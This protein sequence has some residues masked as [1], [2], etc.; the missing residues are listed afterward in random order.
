MKNLANHLCGCVLVMLAALAVITTNVCGQTVLYVRSDVRGGGD[1]LSWKTAYNDLQVAL[2][3]AEGD[4]S[5]DQIWVAAG[6]YTPA[7]PDGDREL[8][9]NLI[10]GVAIYGHFAGFETSIHE[11]DFSNPANET[12]LS[13]DLNGDDGPDFQN[14]GENSYHVVSAVD[15]DSTALLDGFTIRGGNAD[16]TAGGGNRTGGGILLDSSSALIAN[17]QIVKNRALDGGSAIRTR[18]TSS[19]VCH[20]CYLA[21]NLGPTTVWI[22]GEFIFWR[23]RIVENLGSG[24]NSANNTVRLYNCEVTNNQG[25]GVNLQNSQ[26]SVIVQSVIANSQSTGVNLQGSQGPVIVQSVIANNA[27]NIN[28]SGTAH[29]FIYNTIIY[30]GGGIS[31]GMHT[32]E[33]SCIRAGGR[34][35][36]TSIRTRS[37]S[38]RRRAIFASSPARRALMPVTTMRCRRTSSISTATGTRMNRFRSILTAGCASSTIR[39]RPTPATADRPLSIWVPMSS[40]A[41]PIPATTPSGQTTSAASMKH[42]RTGR[43]LRRAQTPTYCSRCTNRTHSG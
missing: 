9:F 1:G 21:A 27:G 30:G 41:S 23:S 24:I 8:S 40:S 4:G 43:L 20:D 14:Y 10:S 31:H 19:P 22:S 35:S 7:P 38:I 29:S 25:T 39:R 37:S 13:G 32:V 2:A 36:G 5:V 33:Y 16:G 12:I 42:H 26:S 28:S 15:V 17:C 11:R 6:T 18:F 3:H 34:A